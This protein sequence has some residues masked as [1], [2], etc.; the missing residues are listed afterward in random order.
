MRIAAKLCQLMASSDWYWLEVKYNNMDL[1][2]DGGRLD[3]SSADPTKGVENCPFKFKWLLIHCHGYHRFHIICA[4]FNSDGLG[5]SA[6]DGIRGGKKSQQNSAGTR[7]QPRNK[8]NNLQNC[9]NVQLFLSTNG[10]LS[11]IYR[12]KQIKHCCKEHKHKC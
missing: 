11:N 4:H 2:G 3:P 10:I 12:L 6:K 7:N 1:L 9:C 8:K 5:S